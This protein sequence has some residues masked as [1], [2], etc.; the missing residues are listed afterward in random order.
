MT[1]VSLLLLSFGLLG[2]YPAASRQGGLGGRLLQ[3]GIIVSLIEW[4]ALII[5]SGMRHFVIHLMQRSDL[6]ADGSLSAADFEAA[7]LAVHTDLTAVTLTFIALFPLATIMV[8][9]G[10]SKR[11]DAMD[12]YKLTS[13]VLAIGGV[14]GLV[15]YL[16]AMNAP[17]LG[18]QTLLWVNSVIFCIQSIGCSSSGMACTRDVGCARDSPGEWF[19]WLRYS[20]GR[21]CSGKTIV[22]RC[23]RC[24]MGT[25]FLQYEV[26]AV[27]RAAY[28]HVGQRPGLKMLF[29]TGS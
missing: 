10:M 17:D 16:T 23:A 29:W 9:I 1:L 15:I 11:F 14:I 5:A 18:I 25:G 21:A 12:V 6:P 22:G 20:R 8:G 28:R 27:G 26:G 3:F 4:S 19:D 13:Y 2:L 24:P 7:A